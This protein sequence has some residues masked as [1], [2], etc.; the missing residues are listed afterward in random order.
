M[1][2]LSRRAALLSLS[3][4]CAAPALPAFAQQ[5]QTATLDISGGFTRASPKVAQAGAA[6]MTIRS[7]GGADRLIG[8]TSPNCTQPELHTHIHDNGMMKMRRVEAIDI[9]AGG[10]AL[11]KPGGLHLMLIG[12]TTPLTEGATVPVTLIFEQAGE[13]PLSLPVKA[14]GAMN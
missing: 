13:V 9:P 3:A 7:R 5:A 14:A 4:L 6:F 11:L 8:F 1:R 2:T 10:E 12:L